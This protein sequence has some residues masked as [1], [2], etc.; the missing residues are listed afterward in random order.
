MRLIF[1]EGEKISDLEINH[2]YRM[3]PNIILCGINLRVFEENV[4]QFG[5]Q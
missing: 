4:R 5:K 3:S 2:K 1:K